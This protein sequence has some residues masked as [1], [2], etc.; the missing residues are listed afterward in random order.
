[1]VDVLTPEQRR[2]NMSRIRGRDTKPEMQIRSGLHACGFRYR[3]HAKDLPGQPDIVLPKFHAAVFIHGCFWHG[4]DCRL[5]KLPMTRQQFWETK[6]RSNRDRDL[7]SVSTLLAMGWRVATIWECSLR[8]RD[9]LGCDEVVKKC[10]EFLLS[11]GTPRI[12][13]RGTERTHDE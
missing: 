13:V 12:D 10:R 7:T 1:M 5:F 4:H 2:L 3:L 8:G 11:T 9:K 6:I